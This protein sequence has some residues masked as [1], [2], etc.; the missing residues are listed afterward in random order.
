MKRGAPAKDPK[1]IARQ[2][3]GELLEM[4]PA[5][6]NGYNILA[7]KALYLAV[8]NHNSPRGL[9]KRRWDCGIKRKSKGVEK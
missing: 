6:F 1:K 9:R 7:G 2:V 4:F 3:C 5:T 8:I